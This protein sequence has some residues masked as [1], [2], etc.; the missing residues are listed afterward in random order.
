M[1][2][3]V[4]AF[5]HY[6]KVECQFSDETITSYLKDLEKFINFLEASG[7]HDLSSVQLSD[8]RFFVAH[9]HELG[10]KP[11]SIKRYISSLRHAFAFFARENIISENPFRYLKAPKLPKLLPDFFYEEEIRE[12]LKQIPRQTPL[13]QRNYALF[14]FLYGTGARASE[15]VNLRLVDIN[16]EDQLVLLHGKGGKDR[17]LPFGSYCKKALQQYLNEGRETLLQGQSS[18]YL[19]LN[20]QGEKLTTNGL[21]FIL[22]KIMKESATQ[23]AIH[24]H[25]LRHS[26]ATHLLN[27]GADIRTVQELLGHAS[28]STTQIYTHLSRD[29]LRKKYN[30]F[31][32]RAKRSE[33][34]R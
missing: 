24:P 14:E 13:E 8:A 3:A 5:Q 10:L 33:K 12:I 20:Y 21:R 16:L 9:L 25:K 31:H 26:F 6:L 28:L 32:P 27:H 18:S 30:T 2:K 19:F 34:E 23:L 22:N 15:A 4:K 7:S 17:Y 29:S 1:F 11:S